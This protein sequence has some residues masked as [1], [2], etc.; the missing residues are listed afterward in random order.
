MLSTLVIVQV[1]ANCRS[2]EAERDIN[3]CDALCTKGTLRYGAKSVGPSTPLRVEMTVLGWVVGM[4]VLGLGG[5]KG[6][7]CV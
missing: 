1:R 4:S 3:I 2:L 7:K 5:M 6:E